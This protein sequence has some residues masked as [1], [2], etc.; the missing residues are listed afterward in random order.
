M[1]KF[2]KQTAALAGR[3]MQS[4]AAARDT[5]RRAVWV[6]LILAIGLIVGVGAVVVDRAP[7]ETS[8]QAGLVLVGA[9]VLGAIVTWGFII[10]ESSRR[11]RD[12]QMQINTGNPL[13]SCDFS[14]ANLDGSYLRNR[15]MN[16]IRLAHA[17][18]RKADF[19]GTVMADA[20]LTRSDARDARFDNIDGFDLHGFRADFRGAR[21]FKA[22]LQEAHFEEADLRDARFGDADLTGADMRKADL[23]GA[24]LGSAT[25]TAVKFD[26]ALYDS[27]TVWPISMHGDFARSARGLVEVSDRRL[28]ILRPEQQTNLALGAA[29]II[30]ALFVGGLAI[31]NS[32]GSDGV[33]TS[34][35]P[36]EVLGRQLERGSVVIEGEGLAQVSIDDGI[37]VPLSVDVWLP[38]RTTIDVFEGEQEINVAVVRRVGTGELSCAVEVDGAVIAAE[39]AL[40]ENASIVCSGTKR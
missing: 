25:V 11:R 35:R 4:L 9:G 29:S 19:T 24:D 38:Y 13:D 37:N 26:G 17:N 31:A 7:S 6:P 28:P 10:G 5:I 3:L 34:D 22:N 16:S 30:A 14:A 39:T 2:R 40:G 12:L 32:G 23:R 1:K 20:V 15:Q 33:P 36:A 27:S 8:R 21:F 18:L